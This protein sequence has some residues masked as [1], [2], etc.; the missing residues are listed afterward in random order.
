MPCD[1]LSWK[2][3]TEW[4]VPTGGCVDSSPLVVRSRGNDVA[5]VGSHSGLVLCTELRGGVI[6]WWTQ[7]RGRVES[8]PCVSNCGEYIIIGNEYTCNIHVLLPSLTQF[9]F[10]YLLPMPIP[11]PSIS[12]SLFICP[13]SLQF[14]LL[15][16]SLP[17]SLSFSQVVMMVV[18]THCVLQ[19]VVSI[20]VSLRKVLQLK[21][22][23]SLLRC[24]TQEPVLSGLDRTISISTPSIF[25]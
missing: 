17:P 19:L 25:T 12:L 3:V 2:L 1:V 10:V 23:S 6:K 8:S 14:F 20:G 4:V 16:L 13:P 22:P 5:Y 24:L 7:L 21:N 18:F 11:P 9:I 15:L